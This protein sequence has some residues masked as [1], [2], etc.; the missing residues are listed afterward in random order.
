[1]GVSPEHGDYCTATWS[2]VGNRVVIA[3]VFV[4]FKSG[5]PGFKSWF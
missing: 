4:V 2:A 1:M 5:N 3:V